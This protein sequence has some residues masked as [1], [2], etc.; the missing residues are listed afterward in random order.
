MRLLP[1]R[2]PLADGASVVRDLQPG[3]TAPGAP[4]RPI[5]CV[6]EPLSPGLRTPRGGDGRL[7]FQLPRRDDS[8][9]REPVRLTSLDPLRAVRSFPAERSE[10]AVA[11]AARD[12]IAQP[13]PEATR[14]ELCASAGNGGA[15]PVHAEGPG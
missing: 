4:G 8:A 3:R 5:D 6:R 10:T 12:L 7:G 9:R 2:S 11:R 15:E 1:E 14:D 13:D